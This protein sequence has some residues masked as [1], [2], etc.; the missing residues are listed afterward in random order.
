[1]S[2]TLE[3]I[4]RRFDVQRGGIDAL[5]AVTAADVAETAFRMTGY[6][7]ES[8]IAPDLRHGAAKQGSK[9]GINGRL[10]YLDGVV[11]VLYSAV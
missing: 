6:A 11:F 8:C 3:Q 9:I 7:G 2:S 1:M 4:V 10:E 5:G